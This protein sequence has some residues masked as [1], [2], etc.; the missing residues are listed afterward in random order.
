MPYDERLAERVRAALRGR[1]GI[2]EKRMFGGLAILVEGH[3]A[4]GVVGSEL[5]V[6][7]G[8]DAEA[9]ALSRRHARPMDF[10][11]RPLRGFVFVSAQG[12]ASARALRS[13]VEQGVA[14]ARSLPAR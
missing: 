13:W 1:P 2:S 11:G 12:L 3:M 9:R 4:C 5:M 14:F 7:V 6:R 8:P 10:S